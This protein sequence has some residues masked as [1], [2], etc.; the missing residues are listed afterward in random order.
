MKN[1][2]FLT[3]TNPMTILSFVG[4]FAGFGLGKSPGYV[5]AGALVGG[6]FIGSGLWGLLLSSGVWLFRS[7][8]TAGWRRAVN[9]LSGGFFFAFGLYSVYTSTREPRG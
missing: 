4:V 7:R 5:G 1:Y 2:L 9:R 6:V 8:V 3:L